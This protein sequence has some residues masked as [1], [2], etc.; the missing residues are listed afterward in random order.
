MSKERESSADRLW[1]EK[2]DQCVSIGGIVAL[3][4]FLGV[5]LLAWLVAGS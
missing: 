5:C 4:Y 2:L 3:G 1:K